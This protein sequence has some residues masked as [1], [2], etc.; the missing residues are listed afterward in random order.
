MWGGFGG[1]GAP[2][3]VGTGATVRVSSFTPSYSP[4]FGSSSAGANRG[5]PSFFFHHSAHSAASRR[6]G[7]GVSARSVST[8]WSRVR[9]SVSLASAST[10]AATARRSG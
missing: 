7:A 8:I 5:S 2:F 1:T 4:C 3:F 10:S 6:Q 9:V